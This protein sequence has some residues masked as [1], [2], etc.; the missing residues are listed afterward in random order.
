MI[1]FSQFLKEDAALWHPQYY[2]TLGIPRSEMPQVKG[3]NVTEFL[4]WS[5]YKYRLQSGVHPR[6]FKATQRD[7]NMEKV[8]GMMGNPNISDKPI[9]VSE[10]GYVVDGHHRW[11]AALNAGKKISVYRIS[12]PIKEILKKIEGYP[13]VFSKSIKESAK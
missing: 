5:G 7:F 13:K 9:M 6:V 1:K 4:K 10:D 12:A 3:D 2:Q 8:S 11:L